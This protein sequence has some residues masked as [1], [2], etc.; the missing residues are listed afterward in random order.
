MWPFKK[1]KVGKWDMTANEAIKKYGSATAVMEEMFNDGTEFG[2]FATDKLIFEYL[3]GQYMKNQFS[4]SL[5][6][7]DKMIKVINEQI[8]FPKE[9][10]TL[11]EFSKSQLKTIKRFI[12]SFN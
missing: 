9:T 11:S 4:S 7:K 1:K 8:K 2:A 5:E 6:T 3:K 10:Y 12:E